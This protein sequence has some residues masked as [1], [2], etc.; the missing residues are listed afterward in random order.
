MTLTHAM[1]QNQTGIELLQQEQY[2]KA[3]EALHSG[4]NTLLSTTPSD[5]SAATDSR[6]EQGRLVYSVPIIETDTDD[7]TDIFVAFC[8]ALD[9]CTDDLCPDDKDSVHLKY[10]LAGIITFNI[11]LCH[12]LHWSKTGKSA[13]LSEA[14]YFYDLAYQSFHRLTLDAMCN[15]TNLLQL[16]IAACICNVGF[17]HTQF[18]SLEVAAVCSDDLSVRLATLS[19]GSVLN[20]EE[21]G[22][23]FVNACFFSKNCLVAASA[24]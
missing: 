1:H 2:E 17:I 15:K 24:A 6:K 11:A 16:G 23:F 19:C 18:Q 7:D 3:V 10:L 12:Q 4:L 21:F 9:L 14:L 8:R 5:P 22:I 20:S 13:L